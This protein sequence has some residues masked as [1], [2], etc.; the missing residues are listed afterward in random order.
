M[1]KRYPDAHH[2]ACANRI[3]QENVWN[4]AEA[5]WPQAAA[6]QHRTRCWLVHTV[7]TAF[8]KWLQRLQSSTKLCKSQIRANTS[9]QRLSSEFFG[10]FSLQFCLFRDV[11]WAVWRTHHFWPWDDSSPTSWSPNMS[12]RLIKWQRAR[13]PASTYLHL[14]TMHLASMDDTLNLQWIAKGVVL[15]GELEPSHPLLEIASHG[16]YSHC[17]LHYIHH[18]QYQ[19]P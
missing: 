8:Y 1:D 17:T 11:A 6:I 16:R 14:W 5:S 2:C 19:N 4:V 3:Q 7:F 10:W 13:P 9:Q 18:D 12:S 15:G